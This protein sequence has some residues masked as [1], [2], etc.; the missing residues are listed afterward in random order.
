MLVKRLAALTA[1]FLTLSLL[2]TL[3][4]PPGMVASPT[5][6][7]HVP[8]VYPT[9]AQ[10][11]AAAQPGDT[12][13]VAPGVYHE[14]GLSVPA[15]V[16]LIGGGWENTTINGGGSGVVV[17]ATH[18][19]LVQGFTIRG[20]GAGYFDAGL[21]VS[22]GSVTLRQN[23]L[24]TNS[25]GIWAWCFAPATCAIH[26]IAEGNILDGNSGTAVNS[27]SE[28]I[29][30]LR[31]NTIIDNGDNGVILNNPASLA[32]N[33]II[34]GHPQRGLVNHVGAITRYNAVWDN[35]QNYEG[36][37]PGLGD[38]P[39]DPL[40]RDRAT[41]DYRLRAASPVIGY[42]TPGGADMGAFPFTPTGAPPASVTLTPQGNNAW[43]VAWTPA[44][45]SGYTLYYG[46]CTRE[47]TTVVP[48]GAVTSYTI[49][50]APPEAVT[51]VAVSAYD[52]QNRESAA[53]L[54]DGIQA[55]CPTAPANLEVGAFPAGE[56]RLQWQDTSS[57]E[58]GFYLE[59]T[60]AT[61][62]PTSYTL[63]ATLPANTVV[64][65]DTPPLLD[66]TYWYRLRAFNSQ[67]VSPTSNE[68]YNVTFAYAPNLDEEYLLVLINEARA[69]PGV[70]GYPTIPATAPLAYNPLLNYAAHSHSQAILNSGF[71]IGH[72]DPIGRCPTERARAVGYPGGVGENLIA[73]M[74]GPACVE[75]SNQAFMDSEGHRNNRLCPCFNEA[76]L[77]H[78]YDPNKGDG[79]WHG[80]YTETFSSRPEVVIP[81]LPSGAV[82]PYT[83]TDNTA[84]TYLVNFYSADGHAPTMARVY[85]DGAAR[86]LTLRS[87]AASNGTYQYTTTLPQG[88]HAYYFYF[89]YGPG[90]SAR[91]P[92]TGVVNLPTVRPQLANLQPTWL[93]ADGLVT[94]QSGM[95][96]AHIA[97]NGEIAAANV[98]VRFY[99]GDPQ[100]GGVQI[101]Q[102]QTIAQ[103][104]PGQTQTVNISWQPETAGTHTLY[105]WADPDNLIP[106]LDTTDNVLSA[107]VTVQSASAIWYVDGSVAASGDGLTPATAFKIVAEG[108]VQ[109]V[110]GN[111]VQVAP[112]VYYERVTV[113]AHVHLQGSGFE[114]TTLHG[115][116]AD[117]SVLGVQHG[118]SVVGFT[119][120]GSGNGYFDSGIW[121][122][123]GEI[124]V[125]NNHFKGNSVGLFSWCFEP[126]CAAVALIENNIFTGNSN[127]AV[128]A[129]GDPVH[130]IVNNTVV[131]NQRGLTLNNSGSLAENNI[132]AQ[133]NTT[134]L[135][136]THNPTVQYNNAWG[137]GVDV[138]G[139]SPGPGAISADPL[140]VNAAA[141]N[142]R[143]R[144]G[145]P[146]IN[147]GNPAPAYNDLDGSRN[148]MGA[149]G[150][151]HAAATGSQVAV[152]AQVA[153]DY[154]VSGEPITVTVTLLRGGE[155]ATAVV[156]TATL[157]VETTYIPGSASGSQG[158]VSDAGP[159]VFEVGDLE[160]AVTLQWSLIA[161]E[162]GR[163]LLPLTLRW[164]G[165]GWQGDLPILVDV[166]LI[167]LPL[168][169]S[170]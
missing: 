121:H 28:P 163:L 169:V 16:S 43:L 139:V 26:L 97:N 84:F 153:P 162:G 113:P 1:V 86:P 140:F 112:G 29:F 52:G 160:T 34:V 158:T 170:R 7:R 115:G 105:V 21:W 3:S 107:T 41:S 75:S 165:G 109:A 66:E 122:S 111:T 114:V 116:G 124:T 130:R 101:G 64:Y 146:A 123:A 58:D 129:N 102:T 82:V 19:S 132:I 78:T 88:N 134:G 128:D 57:L 137:N 167:F 156:L 51:Y 33:N 42:G 138:S 147:A 62:N 96:S 125:R 133:N 151:P 32:E 72:C 106:E 159:L 11:L 12:V 144:S 69:D 76:G 55:P 30:T 104:N 24:T 47:T 31:H 79:V 38:L 56:I 141:D 8:A 127:A 61:L 89:E 20:S 60:Q 80:Q 149:Y 39:L 27:N 73:G 118:G 46:S 90:L 161:H 126:T 92:E 44:A 9:I 53:R 94:G 70:Y 87:G 120:T 117:G 65:T 168:V 50:N 95:V 135:A 83:G 10:G 59:R 103:L 100:Q 155:V 81:A 14:T 2:F 119:I 150:G 74:T 154:P 157:P 48:V 54:A 71:Q 164:H 23:R 37:A 99:R 63:I 5:A 91:W 35:G 25:A 49:P 4:P 142:Y 85:I 45:G 110:A 148:D 152:L 15:N 6:V 18:N 143:L 108:L 131:A 13:Q 77:G 145:S 68:S 22:Q 17:Y 36:M 98:P 166:A 93:W 40:F 67:G 136:A